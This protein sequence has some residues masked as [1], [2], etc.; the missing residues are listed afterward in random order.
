MPVEA[1]FGP[2][3]Y[4]LVLQEEIVVQPVDAFGNFFPAAVEQRI[5]PL[6][7]LTGEI[8]LGRDKTGAAKSRSRSPW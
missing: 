4:G 2:G 5:E 3:S 7:I 1:Q 8:L 6:P